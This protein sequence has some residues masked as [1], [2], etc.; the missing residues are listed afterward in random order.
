MIDE[1]RVKAKE[2][3]VGDEIG[4]EVSGVVKSDAV[5]VDEVVL[6]KSKDIL[7]V[8]MRRTN[9]RSISVKMVV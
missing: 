5:D 8:W 1:A 3:S 6:D 9:R 2:M 4:D 7:V